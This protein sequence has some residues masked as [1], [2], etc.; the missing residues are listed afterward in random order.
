MCQF[1]IGWHWKRSKTTN[2]DEGWSLKAKKK[3]I[4]VK[5]SIDF[6]VVGGMV[7]EVVVLIIHRINRGSDA[8]AVDAALNAATVFI[9]FHFAIVNP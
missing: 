9:D 2:D 4:Q 1:Y 3:K 8:M 7:G 5:I 6:S